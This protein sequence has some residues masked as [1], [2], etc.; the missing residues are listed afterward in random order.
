MVCGCAFLHVTVDAGNLEGDYHV[1]L[2]LD[3]IGVNGRVI[4]RIAV[5]V[6]DLNADAAVILQVAYDDFTRSRI[7]YCIRTYGA[8]SKAIGQIG[9]LDGWRSTQ[10]ERFAIDLVHI[11]YRTGPVIAGGILLEVFAH[12]I[13]GIG[14][15]DAVTIGCREAYTGDTVHFFNAL[16]GLLNQ[17][18]HLGR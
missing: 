3:G 2:E 13:A 7:D 10:L 5:L 11:T 17:F 15:E 12:T 6:V 16:G 9:E 1:L 4:L 18:L 8:Q 14:Q